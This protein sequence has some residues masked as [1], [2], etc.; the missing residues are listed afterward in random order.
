MKNTE[1]AGIFNNIADLLEIKGENPFRVRA[2]RKAA[3]IITALDKD[4]STLSEAELLELPGV[5]HDLAA[6]IEEFVKTGRMA[7]YEKLKLDIPE[8]LTSLL[9]IPG[10][11]PKTVA[12]LYKE[13]DI[14][15]IESLE[16]LAREHRLSGLPGIKDKT[17]QS[18]LK[19]IEMVRRYSARHPL[20]KVLPLANGIREYLFASAPVDKLSIAGSLRRWKD[21]IKDIDIISTS[22]DPESVMKV[23]I[24]MP[25]VSRI[26][27]RG[28][29]NQALFLI[30]AYRSIYAL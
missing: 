6:K 27:S 11:G 9:A 21:T 18:I 23:F 29:R 3:F 19:G 15:D 10:L 14:R 5:G 22:K 16:R 7:A 24:H 28:R 4:V 13:Y 20:G 26:I 1:I 17:E 2:Y 30:P 12:H 25:E 8:S